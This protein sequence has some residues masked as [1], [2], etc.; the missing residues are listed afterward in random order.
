MAASKEAAKTLE[1]SSMGHRHEL[2]NAGHT[3]MSK[4]LREGQTLDASNNGVSG[5]LMPIQSQSSKNQLKNKIAKKQHLRSLTSHKLQAPQKAVQLRK[6]DV[7][8]DGSHHV[9]KSH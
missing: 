8:R 9:N 6:E 1:V 7:Q 2:Q 5:D 4:H 3:Q